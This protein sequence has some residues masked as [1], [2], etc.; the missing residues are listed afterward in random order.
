MTTYELKAIIDQRIENGRGEQEV[1]I[2]LNDGNGNTHM[3]VR[4][5]DGTEVKFGD[6][7]YRRVFVI[8]ADEEI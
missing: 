8:S 3:T 4:E 1:L 2:C 5:A 6:M 7:D